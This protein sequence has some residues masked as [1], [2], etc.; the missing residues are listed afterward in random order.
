MTQPIHPYPHLTDQLET[1]LTTW[2]C[3]K[4][5]RFLELGKLEY[6]LQ[7]IETSTPRLRHYNGDSSTARAGYAGQGAELE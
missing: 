1:T 3:I 6:I 7:Y 5:S 2:L 4:G